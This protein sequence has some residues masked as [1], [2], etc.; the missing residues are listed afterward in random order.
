VGSVRSS[1]GASVQF[2]FVDNASVDVQIASIDATGAV[3]SY[4]TLIP[5][6]TLEVATHV[7]DYWVVENSGGGCLAVVGV[8]GGGQATVS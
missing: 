1:D 6:A 7:G 3:S 4:A 2:G 5:G 8:N